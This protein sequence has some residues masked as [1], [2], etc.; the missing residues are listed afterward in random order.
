MD[1]ARAVG[2]PQESLAN[3]IRPARPC[4]IWFAAAAMKEDESSIKL[5]REK[6]NYCYPLA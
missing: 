1:T 2:S 3:L 6:S 5:D 4:A